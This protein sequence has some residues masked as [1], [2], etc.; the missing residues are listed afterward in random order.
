MK[1][2]KILIIVISFII[3]VSINGLI[4][5]DGKLL[6]ILAIPYLIFASYVWKWKPKRKIEDEI[7]LRKD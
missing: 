6:P 7:T 1:A 2:I 4:K 3:I 5:G